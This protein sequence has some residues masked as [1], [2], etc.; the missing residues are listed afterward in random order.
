M[1]NELKAVITMY[2]SKADTSGNV[3]SFATIECTRTG[4]ELTYNSGWGW[5]A[6]NLESDLK[7]FLNYRHG[8]DY[9]INKVE[10]YATYNQLV[11]EFKE[12]EDVRNLTKKDLNSIGLRRLSL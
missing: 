8:K 12:F 4:K 9:T 11:K 1:K 10:D 2:F 6:S 3:Y 7:D 5:S